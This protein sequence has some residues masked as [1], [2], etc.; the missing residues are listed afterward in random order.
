MNSITTNPT[1]RFVCIMSGILGAGAALLSPNTGFAQAP[2]RAEAP[3]PSIEFAAEPAVIHSM[4]MQLFLP[5]QSTI[6]T[7]FV[8]G[9]QSRSIVQPTDLDVVWVMYIENKVS[10]KD[11]SPAEM[12]D[13][14]V[15]LQQEQF[16]IRD[17]RTDERLQSAIEVIDRTDDLVINGIP[18][19][20]VYLGQPKDPGYPVVGYTMLRRDP[21]EYVVF[22]FSTPLASFERTRPIFEAMTA[23]AHFP[24]RV[25]N[26]EDRVEAV[27]AGSAFLSEITPE[28][29]ESLTSSEPV[30]MRVFKPSPTGRPADAE[31]I[32]YQKLTFYKGQLGE[33]D[34]KKSRQYWT[35]PEREFGFIVRQDARILLDGVV[36]DTRSMFYLST[37]REREMWSILFEQKGPDELGRQQLRTTRQTLARDGSE[38]RVQ[39]IRPGSVPDE[40]AYE[41]IDEHYLSAVERYV[42]PQLV[43]RRYA[44]A[45]DAVIDLGFY[46]FYTGRA[47]VTLRRERF[48]HTPEGGWLSTTTPSEG[49]PEWTSTYD[50]NGVLI[51]RT[52]GT[53]VFAPTTR[54]TLKRIWSGKRLP[55]D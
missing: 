13:G 27:Q 16:V 46:N 5:L 19:A 43:A 7:R 14:V 38:L 4:G 23:S 8:Q 30:F 48:E 2:S 40:K 29:L 17:R 1:A 28:E 37:D 49:Q 36:L 35:A 6:Q 42:L 54:E 10:E 47:V 45:R 3:P 32:G 33:L 9:G 20:R 24:N 21:Q 25:A 22:Q 12:L 26:R 51:Q 53:S 55:I 18:A 50:Q 15:L 31:E 11:L 34:P 44:D 39:T 41:I 52:A